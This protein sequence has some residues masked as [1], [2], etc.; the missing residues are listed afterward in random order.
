MLLF[1]LLIGRTLDHAMRAKARAAVG[2]LAKLTA[3]VKKLLPFIVTPDWRPGKLTD[4]ADLRA[5]FAPPAEQLALG[6]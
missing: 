3:S 2:D 5:R 4:S 1:F 6:L